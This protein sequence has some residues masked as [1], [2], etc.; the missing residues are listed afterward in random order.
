MAS[1]EDHPET[2]VGSKWSDTMAFSHGTAVYLLHWLPVGFQIQFKMLAYKNLICFRD[3]LSPIGSTCITHTVRECLLRVP[4]YQEVR[5]DVVQQKMFSVAAPLFWNR[6]SSEAWIPC[7]TGILNGHG[8]PRWFLG[9]TRPKT[10]ACL[11]L[12]WCALFVF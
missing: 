8:N 4:I 12:A 5:C 1:Q 11:F 10:R 3:N 6:L 7:L 2:L 9:I